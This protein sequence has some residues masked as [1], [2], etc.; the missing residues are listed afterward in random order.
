MGSRYSRRK[1]G[2]LSALQ[3]LGFGTLKCMMMMMMMHRVD[4]G[5]L[6]SLNEF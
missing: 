4:F 2:D 1:D 3:M 5:S 6:C